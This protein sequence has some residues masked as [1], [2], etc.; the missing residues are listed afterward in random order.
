M[1]LELFGNDSGEFVAD[2]P[3]SR[4]TKNNNNNNHRHQ[5]LLR[6]L[7]HNFR[8]RIQFA[9]FMT[10]EMKQRSKVFFD[11]PTYQIFMLPH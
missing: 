10:H 3:Y 9:F 6:Y 7:L 1:D 8:R 2:Q 4:L 11:H 5:V